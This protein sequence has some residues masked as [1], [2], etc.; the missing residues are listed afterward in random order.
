MGYEFTLDVNPNPIPTLALPL[1]GREFRF[2]QLRLL[3]RNY[4]LKKRP[5][6]GDLFHVL[7]T[8]RFLQPQTRPRIGFQIACSVPTADAVVVREHLT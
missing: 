6:P 5:H 2:R 8:W 3:D 1:K 4:H 7:T